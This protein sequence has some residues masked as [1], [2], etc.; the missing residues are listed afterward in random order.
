[1]L[2]V[3]FF[4]P[5]IAYKSHPPRSCLRPA[6]A[7]CK[8][9]I[10]SHFLNHLRIF[11][12]GV[13][14]KVN[15]LSDNNQQ[16][17]RCTVFCLALNSIN[18]L[19]EFLD[20]LRSDEPWCELMWELNPLELLKFYIFSAL[21]HNGSIKP[22]GRGFCMPQAVFRNKNAQKSAF[23]IFTGKFKN[24]NLG[25][26]PARHPHCGEGCAPH[27]TQPLDPLFFG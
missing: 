10:Y 21:P 14:K 15:F 8:S 18:S 2:F 6:R 17:I 23:L 27:H 5:R 12:C 22:A 11:G 20:F 13:E 25:R 3:C 16:T 4:T 24:V 9:C 19:V 26:L 7:C 1:M